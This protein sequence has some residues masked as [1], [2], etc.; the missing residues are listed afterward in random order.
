MKRI[1][2]AG[3]IAVLATVGF[4]GV[5]SATPADAACFGQVHKA[6]NAGVLGVDNVGQLV[7]AVGGGQ[8]KNAAARTYC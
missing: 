6:V 7:Q 4:A 1:I 2:I 8:E 3:S 5:A